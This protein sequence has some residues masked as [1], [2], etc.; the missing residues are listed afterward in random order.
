M[1]SEAG[2]SLDSW[3][4][5]KSNKKYISMLRLGRPCLDF[6]QFTISSFTLNLVLQISDSNDI[7]ASR[8][9]VRD[10]RFGGTSIT[11][12][13]LL[14]NSLGISPVGLLFERSRIR[15]FWKL[16]RVLGI[17]P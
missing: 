16:E 13:R 5:D 6:F 4:F 11:Y 14:T 17:E 8:S 9:G 7:E 10:V 3:L 2:I 15:R 12:V 1:P